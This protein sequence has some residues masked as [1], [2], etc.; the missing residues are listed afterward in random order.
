MNPDESLLGGAF[1]T[2]ETTFTKGIAGTLFDIA[3]RVGGSTLDVVGE[4]RKANKA[5]QQYADRYQK[6]Y[7]LLRLLGMPQGVALESIYTP[8]RVL[9]ELSIRNFET[10]P[11][12]EENYRDRDLRRLQRGACR[13]EDGL[14]VA[15]RNQYLMVL[16]NPGGGKS[17]FL[18]RLGLEAFAGEQGKF[19]DKR[20]PVLLELK[21]FNTEQVDLIA[22]IAEEMQHFGFPPSREFAQKALA[23]GK[24]LVLLDGLD[25][26][27]NQFTNSVMRAIDNLVTGHEQNRFVASCRIAAF[28]S[29]FQHDFRVI[30]LADFDDQQIEQFITNWFSSEL[31]RQSDTAQKCW[32]TL[33]SDNNKAAK[34]LA[35][36]P[37]L[38]TFLCLV[39]GRKLNFPPT[40]SRLYNKALDIL[41]EEWAAE[42][43]LQQEPI[44]EGLH[45]DLEKVMLAE[46]AHENFKHDRLFFEE[47]AIVK[48][49]TSFLADSVKDAKYLDGKKILQAIAAQQGILVQRAEDVYSFSHLTLQEHLTAQY[50]NE[51]DRLVEQLITQHLTDKRWREIFLLVAGLKNDASQFLLKM[52]KATRKLIYTDK[53]HRLLVWT[54]YRV[55]NS[56]GDIQPVGKR[57]I[58]LASALALTKN[59]IS[60]LV[61]AYSEDN[62]YFFANAYAYSLRS[63]IAN[64]KAIANTYANTYANADIPALAENALE[65]FI[66]H[67]QWSE[68]YQ[69]YRDVNYSQLIATLKELQQNMP[70]EKEK[71]EVFPAFGKQMIEIWLKAFQLQT[72]MVE[73]SKQEIKELDRYFYANLLMVECEQAAVLVLRKT[74]Q[75][76]ESRMLMPFR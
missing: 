32:E 76:I 1:D 27:P 7:G 56:A 14:T 52:E 41:L 48:S 20:I 57:A 38:L 13:S 61:N 36:T 73:L 11:D 66:D 40:R 31:D 35:Q 29:N 30:E 26:V 15:E 44:H 3:K 49:I 18:R 74:W 17:T 39:Y 67:T 34:E 53:L 37:L 28:R 22:A 8:V 70:Q 72:E 51:N 63:A 71:K 24:L 60:A 6:R 5:V 55:N 25:E 58:V 43:R 54:K 9:N 33:N 19:Q 50:I 47:Q 75:E 16:G 10:I 12:L 59:N 62:T 65:N 42:K 64:T 45:T 2:V 68:Q 23:A 4:K 21:Q 69:I 46:I